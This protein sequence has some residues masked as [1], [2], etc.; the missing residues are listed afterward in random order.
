MPSFFLEAMGNKNNPIK[1]QRGNLG[2]KEEVYPGIFQFL[3]SEKCLLFALDF[4]S[5]VGS[6]AVYFNIF[7]MSRDF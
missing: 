1:T 7:L 5:L 4:K 3:D 6:K 2:A